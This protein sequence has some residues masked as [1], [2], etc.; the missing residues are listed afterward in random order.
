MNLNFPPLESGPALWLVLSK[1]I[2][3]RW[4]CANLSLFFNRPSTFYFCSL[5]TQPPL[6]HLSY[7]RWHHVEQGWAIQ[8]NV[9]RISGGCCEWLC[10]GIVGYIS[11]DNWDSVNLVKEVP[12]KNVEST[13]CLLIAVCYKVWI[14]NA[15]VKASQ[16]SSRISKNI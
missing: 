6:L 3:Q 10:F 16:F 8:L 4:C 12:R 1:G 15:K 7:P 11:K 14:K 5:V 2:H 13:N 9:A